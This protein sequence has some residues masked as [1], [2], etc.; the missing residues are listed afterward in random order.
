[1]P[2]NSEES[3]RIKVLVVDDKT[4]FAKGTVSLL[5]IEPSILV[6]GVAR[7]VTECISLVRDTMPDVILF[8]INLLDSSGVNQIDEIKKVRPE[9]K[10]IIMT[11]QNLQDYISL[12]LGNGA[13]DILL[14]DSSLKEMTQA[15]FR[16]RKGSISFPRRSET[17]PQSLRDITRLPFSL[18]HKKAKK[19]LLNNQEIEIMELVVKG[20]YNK[21]IAAIFGIKVRTVDLHIRNILSKLGISTRFEAVLL[22]AYADKNSFLKD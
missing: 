1:V 21:E 6:V 12:P 14:K 22:W 2:S 9:T 8:D 15:I 18:K 10:I 19:K 11:G 7:N 3:E 5:S 20:F 16:V 4:L 13:T 17:S